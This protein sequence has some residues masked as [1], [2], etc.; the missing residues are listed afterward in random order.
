MSLSGIPLGISA[1]EKVLSEK[2]KESGDLAAFNWETDEAPS[3]KSLAVFI[4]AK[5]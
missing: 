2:W 4:P 1:S 3:M 5:P